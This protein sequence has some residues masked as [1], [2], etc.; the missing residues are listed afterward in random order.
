MLLND[1]KSGPI[2]TTTSSGHKIDCAKECPC[3][4]PVIV[5]RI[6]RIDTNHLQN[7]T[8]EGPKLL[9][10]R[11]TPCTL[12]P[13]CILVHSIPALARAGPVP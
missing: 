4:V 1:T 11:A 6:E 12:L 9:L 8:E 10:M 7:W 13:S 3:N 5:S 2:L